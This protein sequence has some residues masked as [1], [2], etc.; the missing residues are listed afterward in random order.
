MFNHARLFF[1]FWVI[2][3]LSSINTKGQFKC[4]IEHY[5]TEQ[6]LSHDAVTF[7]MKDHEGFM[8]FGTWDG[9]NR[10]DGHN[11][12]AYKS[13]PG[14]MSKLKN[15]RIDEIVE[16][17]SNHLWLRA[18]DK[19]IYRF[20][21]K[22]EQFLPFSNILNASGKKKAAF[23]HMIADHNGGIWLV[24]SLEGLVFISK[25]DLSL[26]H[27]VRYGQGLARDHQLPSNTIHFFNQDFE[28][29]IWLGTSNGLTCLSRSGPDSYKLVHLNTP[30]TDGLNF[31]S[32]GEDR[33]QL[34]FGTQGG[35]LVI[36]NKISKKMT[37]LKVSASRLNSI[38]SARTKKEL[39]I[40]TNKGEL[41]SLNLEDHHI[42]ISS[43]KAGTS[44]LSIFEDH[45]GVLWLAPMDEGIVRFDPGTQAF[46]LF[47]Q[48]NDSKYSNSGNHCQVFE[49]NNGVIWVNMKGGGFGYY[50]PARAAVE[51]FYNRPGAPD[52]Q[53]SNIVTGV[54]YD[55]AGVMW[56]ITDERGINKVIFQRNDFNQQLLVEQG[57]F[58]SDNEVRGIL[59]DRKNR[60]WLG[61]KSGKLYIYQN[62]IKQTRLL[63]NEPPEGLGQV[64]TMLQDHS[65]NIW[66]GTKA[67][68]LFI[69][70][71]QNREETSYKL[72]HYLTGPQ[73]LSSN[74]IYA[75]Q[76]D[77]RGQVWIGTFDAGLNLAIN[78]GQSLKITHEGPAFKNYPR[79]S[80]HKI[81]HMALD[82]DGDLWIATT[83]GLLLL[84]PN[85]H[86]LPTYRYLTYS[87]IPG[88]RSS[89]GN[90]DVQFIYRD[91]RD[92]MWLATSGGGLDQALGDHPFQSLDFKNYT[93]KDGL[94]NDGVLSCT[95]DRHGELWI[96]TQNGLSKLN[97]ARGQFRNYDSYDGLPK[98]G[99]S[100]TSSLRMADGK[101][102]FGTLKGY[103]LFDPDQITDYRSAANLAL[104]NLQI[105]NEDVV[106]GA[107]NAVVKN[108]IN[109]SS[110]L[111]LQHNQNIISF[112][113]AV[114]DYR[115]GV[116]QVYAYRL[117]GFD[118]SW[119][120]NKEQRRATYTNLPFG[121]YVFEVKSL[122]GDLYSTPPYR[123]LNLTILPPPWL[124]WYAYLVYGLLIVLLAF[125][126][127]RIVVTMLRLRQKIAVEQ[128]LAELKLSFFTNVSHELRTPLTLILN[129]IEELGRKEKLSPQGF[130]YVD[131]VRKNASRMVR[132]INQLLD[133]RKLQ[134]GKAV[135]KLSQVEIISFVKKTGEYFA[136]TAAKKRV[137]LRVHADQEQLHAW[138]DVEK[139]D[140]VIYNLLANAFK[141]SPEDGHIDIYISV[142]EQ[143]YLIQ[144]CDQGHGVENSKLNDIFEL[145][146]EA[147]NNSG[148]NLKGTGIGLAL[149]K[150]LIAL[151]H[152]TISA[153]NNP[154]KG[155]TVTVKLRLGK[156]HYHAD[157][158]MYID[159]PD[160]PQAFEKTIEE[161]LS[162]T[163]LQPVTDQHQQA[164]LVLLVEDND[165]LRAFLSVQLSEHYRVEVACDGEEGWKKA[166]Q[167][168]PDLVLSDVMMPKLDGIG[169][170]DRL[171]N[172][173]N[174]SHIPVV[175]LSAKFA[176]E[177]QIEGLRYGA[178][179]YITKPFHN[180]FLLAAIENLLKRRK[181]QFE[182]LLTEKR[183]IELHPAEIVITSQDEIFLK[184][185]ISIVEDRM[186]DPEFN[187]DAVAESLNM[188]RS[189]FYKKFKSLTNLAPV[190]FMRDM[191]LKRA[192]QYLDGGEKNISEISYLVGFSNARY[193]STCFKELYQVSPSEYLKS[194]NLKV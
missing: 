54:Y 153:A 25:N 192:K 172:N 3:S 84:D 33:Q 188:G 104:T 107:D 18:I 15:D 94:S 111:T 177:S 102:V 51:Y 27:Y 32:F 53:L 39:Y 157:E 97:G 122:S 47:S 49:D 29:N 1:C 42:M 137:L 131:I 112:D 81:R 30:L 169:M 150:E 31:T 68:G 14:D 100:E 103:L 41:I 99:F 189:T 143:C 13:A 116:K 174:T 28:N 113:Y 134:S 7:M 125:I 96:A 168:I 11:F 101:L 117:K 176:I 89:L 63:L 191:R 175:L 110:Q 91:H 115:S 139:L 26:N 4:K 160:I 193:F 167:L 88:N 126:I 130:A 135:L 85:E 46:R 10:F 132:F 48:P 20:D 146:Y 187:I 43:Y 77:Q 161:L 76:E 21:K 140:I 23:D 59:C 69:A 8:W 60:L 151:H 118:T 83:D 62:G 17:S 152:G 162:P 145:Y 70:T 119:H 9:I 128:K 127:R 144:V 186:A 163:L 87:K 154:E 36:M 155:L 179:Y 165:D 90:N 24:S 138:V 121:D 74:Q 178:D 57:H 180:D 149:S 2:L 56:L 129:P 78:N 44:L 6:G 147:G 64:Y 106:F 95:E 136:E 109:Y 92:N 159:V 80:F 181:K 86:H 22:T 37:R 35:E 45:T 164:P 105:N 16:D 19:Q 120:N 67:N 183:T 98:T 156:E 50:N 142:S 93:V 124:S 34:Y 133:L 72:A 114:L 108:N 190:E 61:A 184:K 58:K 194:K 73:G 123:R 173:L 79:E 182:S 166:C 158:V 75:L 12:V 148:T 38:H 55:K 141:F 66:L 171:K 71:P 170:L 40:T 82:K 5:S 52:R 65:G 185:I